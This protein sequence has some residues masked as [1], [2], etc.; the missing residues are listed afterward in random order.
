MTRKQAI[1]RPQLTWI[2]RYWQPCALEQ[3]GTSIQLE[4]VTS[5]AITCKGSPALLSALHSG[6]TERQYRHR[7]RDRNRESNHDTIEGDTAHCNICTHLVERWVCSAGSDYVWFCNTLGFTGPVSVGLC[8]PKATQTILRNIQVVVRDGR[9]NGFPWHHLTITTTQQRHTWHPAWRLFQ[10]IYLPPPLAQAKR[11]PVHL[12]RG[13][14]QP[15]N[16]K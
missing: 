3:A 2:P 10:P 8:A 6:T 16:E 5:A 9:V 4:S 7:Q 1:V 15:P 11:P 12:W 14:S 13:V